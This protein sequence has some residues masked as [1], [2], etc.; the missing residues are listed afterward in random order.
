ML[1]R[2]TGSIAQVFDI[3]SLYGPLFK[4]FQGEAYLEWVYDTI[5]D[6]LD[7]GLTKLFAQ[8]FN[9]PVLGKQ[10]S[11]EVN[12]QSAQVWDFSNDGQTKEAIVVAKVTGEIV[13]SYAHIPWQQLTHISGELADTIFRT[14]TTGGL[15][16]Q[17]VSISICHGSARLNVTF[18]S[19]HLEHQI[20]RLS[21]LQRIVSV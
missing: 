4:S 16:P 3:T 19:V 8:H 18:F 15:A 5:K 13:V 12:G 17:D 6:P 1:C 11:T 2:S 10:Y 14:D 7:P 21:S 9:I 20:L